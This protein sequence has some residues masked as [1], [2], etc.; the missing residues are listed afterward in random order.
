MAVAMAENKMLNAALRTMQ[1]IF[2]IIVLGTDGYAIHAYRGYS[3][4]RTTFTGD[5]VYVHYGVPDAWGFLLFCAAWTILVVIFQ[6]IA[7]NAFA[8]HALIS[9]IPVAVEVVAV[10]SWFAGWIAVAVNIGNKACPEGYKSCEALKAATVFGAVE[11]LLFMVTAILA[12]KLILNSKRRPK[13]STTRP[14]A[15]I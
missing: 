13:S 2:A 8:D 6:L 14:T 12:I 9:Y 5:T 10:L 11:W 3:T 15:D 4:W 1:V 7:G